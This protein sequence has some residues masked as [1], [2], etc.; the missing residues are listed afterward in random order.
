VQ[1]LQEEMCYLIGELT[2]SPR[3]SFVFVNRSEKIIKVLA[4]SLG[5]PRVLDIKYDTPDLNAKKPFMLA[6][7]LK[8]VPEFADHPI[9]ELIPNLHSLAAYFLQETASE[10]YMLVAWNP[11][12]NFFTNDHSIAIVE[13]LIV[14]CKKLVED[15]IGQAKQVANLLH[16]TTAEIVLRENTNI[17]HT[18][19]VSK[20]LFDTLI[21]KQRLLARNG[22]SYLT[23]RQWRKSIKSHQIS[24]LEALKADLS[25]SCANDIADEMS[26]AVRKVYGNLFTE[27]VPI[28][29]GSSG[30]SRSFSVLIAEA[31]AEKLNL[32][33]KNILISG[34]V[35]NGSSHPKKSAV[36]KLYQVVGQPTGNVLIVDDVAT[37]GKHNEYASNAI[38]SHVNYCTAIAWITD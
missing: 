37:S 20:F 1:L 17:F 29:G 21:P 32:P 19:P 22:V 25:P 18:E 35:V 9:K 5:K 11:S 8:G 23:V 14:L 31:L 15:E 34:G 3:V 2:G 27:V 38:K 7:S 6:P 33:C 4:S 24:A 28:P 13:R 10:K 26:I 30:R 12:K 16:E 36:L